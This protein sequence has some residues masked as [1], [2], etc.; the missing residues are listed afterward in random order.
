MARV[1]ILKRR[2]KRATP[3]RA[4]DFERYAPPAGFECGEVFQH[5]PHGKHASQPAFTG[6]ARFSVHHLW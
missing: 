5:V 6:S 1:P 4:E 3:H 2:Y